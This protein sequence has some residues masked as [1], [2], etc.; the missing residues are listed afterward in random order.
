MPQSNRIRRLKHIEAFSAVISTGSFSAAARQLGVSQPAISQLIK[1]LEDAIGAP[2]F[3]RRNGA[4]FPTNRAES[5]REDAV[6][7][8]AHLDRFQA[9]LS[10]G[11]TRVLSTI[12]LSASMSI[13]SELLPD[14][15]SQ[16]T[17]QHPDAMFY[18]SSVPLS[19]MVQSLVQGH[20]DFAF[21]TRPLEHPGL[22]NECIVEAPQVAVM[23]ADN[24]LA[25]IEGLSIKDFDG[26]RIITST[27]SDPAFH[28]FAELWRK[29]G[30]SVKT[31][32][33][34][35]FSGFSI[36]MVEAMSAVTFNNALVARKICERNPDLV[37]R[38]VEGVGFKTQFFLACADWQAKSVTRQ[39][40]EEGF[41]MKALP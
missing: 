27:R 30:V 21:H 39:I 33:Q 22:H 13:A 36:R 12:R 28:Y 20:I 24:P 34:S 32:L 17:L 37:M 2:L 14:V 11:R 25:G 5:L 9:Q 18:V 16:I 3:I 31:V 1:A 35:P 4:I 19:A 38:S 8:L 29:N 41:K 10:Y 26:Q 23:T 7:L 40:L 15:V 6:S